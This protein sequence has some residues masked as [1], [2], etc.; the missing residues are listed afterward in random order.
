MKNTQ[1][2][3][4]SDA[5]VS[6]VK[7]T[8]K[9]SYRLIKKYLFPVLGSSIAI[10]SVAEAGDVGNT[11]IVTSLTNGTAY[12]F[13]IT[14]KD[15]TV[16]ATASLAVVLG[17][18]TDGAS[19][20]D[21]IIISDGDNSPAAGNTT[22][23]IASSV[24]DFA[25]GTS[26]V[27]TI[28]DTDDRTGTFAV[29]FSGVVTQK[30]TTI[31]TTAEDTDDE[32]M[33]VN[34][35]GA[36][37]LTGAAALDAGGSNVKGDLNA[38][39]S[40]SAIFT[41]GI[42]MADIS[43]TGSATMTFDGSATQAIAGAIDGNAASEGK[44]NVT[45]TAGAVSF[46]G[47]LGTTTLKMF[48]VG[49][50]ADAIVAGILKS[51]NIKLGD[52]ATLEATGNSALTGSIDGAAAGKGGLIIDN[53]SGVSVVGDI[54]GTTTV[55]TVTLSD[56]GSAVIGSFSADVNTASGIILGD[57]ANN[58]AITANF[59]HAG[60][61]TVTGAISAAD[62]GDTVVINIA[63]STNNAAPDALSFAGAIGV[64]SFVDTI[65]IG[66]ATTAGNALFAGNVEATTLNIL[67]GNTDAEDSTVDADGD[68]TAAIVM[69]DSTA[70]RVANLKLS[71]AG[72]QTVTGAITAQ[73][74][75]EGNLVTAN[76]AGTMTFSAGIGTDALKLD[77]ATIAASNTVVFNGAVAA[78]T[79]TNAGTMTIGA[80]ENES[81]AVSMTAV[82]IMH[83]DKTVVN[84]DKVFNEVLT[85]RPTLTAGSKVY[86]PENFINGQTMTIFE[87]EADTG[88]ADHA[89]T[90]SET[91]AA[92]QDNS[93]IGFSAAALA[94][95]NGSTV[96]TATRVDAATAA[97][98]L[99]VTENQA[100]ALYHAL[101]AAV[102]DTNVD[103]TA[104]D[105][106]GD[107]INGLGGQSATEDTTMAKQVAPQEDMAA[108]NAFVSKASTSTVQGIM[109]NRMASLR[110]G[111]AFVVG[112]SAGNSMSAN[113][114]F[115]QAFGSE[116]EQSN[117]TKNA[118]QTVFGYDADSSGVAI[119]IDGLTESGMV[120]GLSLSNSETDIT[121]KGAGKA[122][123]TVSTYTASV[124]AD[125][126][127]ESGYVEGSL[128]YGLSE[129][130]SSRKLTAGGLNRTYTGDYDSESISLKIGAGAPKETANDVFITPYGSLTGSLISTDTYTEK[131]GTAS[132][133][134]RLKVQ[135]DQ[136]TSLVGSAGLKAHVVSDFGTPMISLQVNNEFG[137]T[138]IN[139]TNTYQGGG[140]AFKTNTK[141][142]EMSAT[143]GLG[144]TFGSDRASLNI[145][146]EGTADDNEYI[147][148]YGS[149]KLVS[150]F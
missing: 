31:I 83:I 143:L 96:V 66:T 144:Y 138:T 61:S 111:D 22:V 3:Q 82:G 48:E 80:K 75:T 127:T 140:D 72:A 123:N 47:A 43:T 86:M 88:L 6:R 110:S 55:A 77:T 35:D 85:T 124:Y 128:T 5:F 67:G 120:L 24:L 39:F 122:K 30:G 116:V 132:D 119:G 100:N 63:D 13:N 113:S 8:I 78:D 103:A 81:E 20:S 73:G 26:G 108:G 9:E 59:T 17:A 91:N 44:I 65:N 99:G 118:N 112:V 126:A 129:N 76:T 54:G 16:N 53:A 2:K 84:G 40:S 14:N 139:N 95:G 92:L 136:I 69:N 19:T 27:L 51:T 74:D 102:D 62:T 45:N 25:T 58:K 38:V 101:V 115:I 29:T 12:N 46:A 60:A 98:N 34:F 107:V 147:S 7:A 57:N 130:K 15:L 94:T 148:H 1:L 142:E 117:T 149:V 10:T 50:S 32:L 150:K 41:G 70:A 105:T 33:T 104:E 109:S 90:V 52:G 131:S 146:Y 4:L 114:G 28:T 37:T 42:D 18:I 79:L 89:T 71:G 87:G 56:A 121:G 36:T 135:S 133:N 145:G 134:L 64:G 137:D 97:V 106:M 49:A 93:I 23:T 11:N 21:L 125:K 68:I 141:V